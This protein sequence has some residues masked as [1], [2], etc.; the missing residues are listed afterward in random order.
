MAF[1]I[2]IT[3][4]A[5]QQIEQSYLWYRERNSDFA[6]RWFRDLM[7]AIATLQ[8]KPK[9]CPLALENEVFADELRQLLYGKGRSA[10][11]ILFTVRDE[12][13]FVLFVRHT[14][15]EPMKPE[16]FEGM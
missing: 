15:Q 5:E 4:T 9:R 10:F 7:N 16:D 13:V 1:R 2:D 14:A 3:S 11:R 12:V 8:E 6:D